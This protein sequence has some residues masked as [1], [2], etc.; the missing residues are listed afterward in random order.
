VKFKFELGKG[1]NKSPLIV[2]VQI[3]TAIAKN[4]TTWQNK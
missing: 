1:K 2:V 4:K 3:G